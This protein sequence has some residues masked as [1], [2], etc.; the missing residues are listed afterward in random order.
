[1]AKSHKRKNSQKATQQN[2]RHE[3][4]V[5]A[6]KAQQSKKFRRNVLLAILLLIVI[7]S[8][9]QVSRSI[10]VTTEGMQ[11]LALDTISEFDSTKGAGDV[12]VIKYSDFQCPACRSATVFVEELL[13]EYSEDVT[14]MYRHF[15]LVGVLPKGTYAAQAAEAARLQ[16]KFWEMHEL[17]FERQPEWSSGNE[18]QL[19]REFAQEIGLDV[20]QFDADIIS[21][22][23]R[24]VVQL[25]AESAQS[26][27]LSATPAFFV[28][29]RQ[30]QLR[31]AQDLATAV[32][33]ELAN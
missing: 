23:V 15:P 13:A 30:V 32:A 16:G 9:W 24:A 17:L 22:Q 14:F 4:R 10:S 31:S 29:G 20:A 19:F 8:L 3:E 2:S 18:R 6:A 33:Q 26:L 27:R 21:P 12:I 7:V 1:M 5:A 11:P 25:H 28:N